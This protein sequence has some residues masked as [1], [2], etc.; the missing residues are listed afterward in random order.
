[1]L[2]LGR[3]ATT[4]DRELQDLKDMVDF[5]AVIRAEEI[6]H[7]TRAIR[8]HWQAQRP[9]EG[10]HPLGSQRSV[11]FA[12]LC[13]AV[14]QAVS[15]EALT[16]QNIRA[17]IHDAVAEL[18][19]STT[20]RVDACTVFDVPLHGARARKTLDLDPADVAACR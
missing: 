1:M 17:K 4:H 14:R 5:V 15:G 11:V 19:Q 20:Q 6:K 9:A 7:S 10:P 3:L 13:D 18:M 12:S 8:A 16:D 2:L